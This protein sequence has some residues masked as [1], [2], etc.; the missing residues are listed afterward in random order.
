[1]NTPPDVPRI[2]ESL[3][4]NQR[5][6]ESSIRGQRRVVLGTLCLC[7]V[8]VA[9]V[10]FLITQGRGG[11]GVLG[12]EP[13]DGTV[14][15]D[16]VQ[17]IPGSVKA[18]PSEV[19]PVALSEPAGDPEAAAK[20]SSAPPTPEAELLAKITALTSQVEQAQRTS[21]A[22]NQEID[23]LRNDLRRRDESLNETLKRLEDKDRAERAAHDAVKSEVPSLPHDPMV[24]AIN[25][26]LLEQ[27]VLDYRL[28]EYAEV[29]EH[30][31]RD[32]RWALCNGRGTAVGVV[33]A[34]RCQIS[35]DPANRSI[36]IRLLDGWIT[37]GAEKDPLTEQRWVV[38]N[39]NLESWSGPPI[40]AL[41]AD[42]SPPQ[43]PPAPSPPS[44]DK[45]REQLTTLLE[46]N[47]FSLRQLDSV[48]GT[49]LK[50]IIVD[51]GVTGT[52]PIRTITADLC[53]IQIVDPGGYVE[54][55]FENGSITRRGRE[56]RFYGNR[57][58]LALPHSVPSEWQQAL[59][60]L[61]TKRDSSRT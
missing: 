8:L 6:L 61:T 28:L 14:S 7:C 56:M 5:A 40:D 15:K 48:D 44:L 17:A 35:K 32:S 34:A 4:T 55:V 31:L 19:S 23:R 38:P 11:Q 58:R 9:A 30:E 10:T 54:V 13:A 20:E 49:D 60:G 41:L 18:K 24:E 22:Q 42:A 39:A 43:K 2:L 51:E 52:T 37:R 29:S 46:K 1:M 57:Y 33:F 45:I 26:R 36:V 16:D 25:A 3:E 53:H 50:R 47:G 12:A 21:R 59:P 27:S